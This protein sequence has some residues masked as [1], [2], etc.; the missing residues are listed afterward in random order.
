MMHETDDTTEESEAVSQVDPDEPGDLLYLTGAYNR[1][2]ITFEEW[3][4]RSRAWA[5][6]VIRERKP[7]K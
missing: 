3:L 1:Q 2:E 7:R 4:R 5:E 6:R